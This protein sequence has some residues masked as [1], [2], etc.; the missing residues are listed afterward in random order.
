[1]SGLNPRLDRLAG[2]AC[3]LMAALAAALTSDSLAAASAAL[4]IQN[5][6]RVALAVP[7]DSEEAI[8]SGREALRRGGGY[9]WYESQS[10]KLRRVQVRPPWRWPD[11]SLNTNFRWPRWMSWIPWIGIVAV[12]L[13]VVYILIRTYLRRESVAAADSQS[14][15]VATAI[16]DEARV[17]ALPFAIRRRPGNLLEEAR[18]HYQQGNF[19]EAIIYLYS[20]LL[21]EL[22]RNQLIR[23]TKGRTNRQYLWEIAARPPLYGLMEQAMI[24]FEDVF[25]GGHAMPRARFEAC[26]SRLDQFSKLIAGA[27]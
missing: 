1:M 19:S 23:L 24:A 5:P 25:F 21:V 22:D 10:D 7:V 20:H 18:L 3:G 15:A 2:P 16:D 11:W 13:L 12:L 26:W 8:T 27:G 4:V 9:P 6:Q 14:H 17:E